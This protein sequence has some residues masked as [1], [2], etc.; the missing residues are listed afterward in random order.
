[1]LAAA[2]EKCLH[3]LGL[4]RLQRFSHCRCL[5]EQRQWLIASD[6][7]DNLY[8]TKLHL[9]NLIR[10]WLGSLEMEDYPLPCTQKF[11]PPNPPP[12]PPPPP[13]RQECMYSICCLHKVEPCGSNGLN[14]V[15]TCITWQHFTS[16]TPRNRLPHEWHMLA[17]N[18]TVH[19]LIY[20]VYLAWSWQI[21]CSWIAR[22]SWKW[23]Q[24]YQV[25]L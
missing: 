15:Q 19:V 23:I 11:P 5:N 24:Q 3:Y 17:N 12:H 21:H 9:P 20:R 22:A 25:M 14:E 16:T 2:L 8:I 7:E 1:M 13:W 4:N 18:D 6:N 10:N